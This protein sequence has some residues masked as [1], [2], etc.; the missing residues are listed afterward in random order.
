[1]KN[2]NLFCLALLG[3]LLLQTSCNKAGELC[4]DFAQSSTIKQTL[5][6]H[7]GLYRSQKASVRLWLTN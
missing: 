7:R 5:S 6:R 4:F 3:F 2:S 1:M